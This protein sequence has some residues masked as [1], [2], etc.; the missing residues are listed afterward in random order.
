MEESSSTKDNV[1]VVLRVR[2]LNKR[3]LGIAIFIFI[4]HVF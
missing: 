2:P 1:K 3:E 4:A